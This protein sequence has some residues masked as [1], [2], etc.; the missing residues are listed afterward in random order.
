MQY[1]RNKGKVS[2]SQY[3]QKFNN[4]EKVNLKIHPSVQK[5]RF[6]PRFHGLTGIIT[7]M[8]GACY[9]VKIKDGNK[10]KILYIHP[11]HLKKT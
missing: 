11:I 7:G 9:Q 5:G 10:E 1:Y 2:V 3:L 6:F 4:G 8:K